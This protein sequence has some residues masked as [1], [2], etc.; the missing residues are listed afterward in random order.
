MGDEV[1]SL[2]EQISAYEILNN[3]IPGTMY[4]GLVERL[5]PFHVFTR[6]LWVDIIICY[7]AG[8]V[9][10]RIGSLFIGELA[11]KHNPNRKDYKL[12]IR[13]EQRNERIRPMSAIR[14]MY[15]SFIS[16][17]MCFMITFL[18]GFVWPY[19]SENIWVKSA[20]VVIGSLALVLLFQKSYGKQHRYV[21]ERIQEAM[22]E[23][24]D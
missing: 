13:A 18:F 1:K 12:Y 14:N 9:I 20:L 23:K 5:T 17:M 22:S 4:I 16:A 8:V 10:G 19:I 21:E 3:I 2:L 11:K 24:K 15:R 6:Q 7:F